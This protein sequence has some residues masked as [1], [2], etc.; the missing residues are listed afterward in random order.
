MTA[1][2]SPQ[3]QTITEDSLLGGRVRLRQPA[4]GYRAAIDPVFLAAS[5]EAGGQDLVLDMGCGVG[6]ATLCLATRVAGCRIAGFDVQRDIVRLA[7]DNIALNDLSGRVSVMHGD[8]LK[9][10]MRLAPGGFDHVMANPPFLEAGTATA[11]AN[12]AA[13]TA[14]LEGAAD[15]AVWVRVA[16]AMVRAKGSVTFIHRADRLEALLGLLA[17]K[18]GEIVVFPLWPGNGKPAKRVIVRARK[19]I[20]TPTRLMPGLVLHRADGGF[21]AEADAVL[22]QGA[23]LALAG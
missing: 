13:A 21:T 18:A 19:Q 8:L 1:L 17:G 15:L 10:P 20:A 11:P 4:S 5:V 23:A 22:R 2:P 7:S 6:A 14:T 16:L 12:P 3:G 9:P